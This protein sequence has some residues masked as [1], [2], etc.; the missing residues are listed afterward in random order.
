MNKKN[1][2]LINPP[3]FFSGGIP[4]SL[5]YSVP[6]LGILY[7]A[8]YVNRYSADFKASVIDVAAERLSLE[9]L[10][11]RTDEIAPFAVGIS[12]MTPQLQG[13]VELA[14]CLKKTCMVKPH[15]F[16]GGP[17]ISADPDFLNRF[18]DIFDFAIT[19][20][21]E[22]TFLESLES[23]LNQKSIPRV[24]TGSYIDDLDSVPFPDRRLIDKSKYAKHESL[25]FSRGCP[26]SCYYCS[27]PSVSNKVRYRSVGNMIEE[28]K[29]LFK[30]AQGRI[31]FQD[32]TFTIDKN[33]VLDL[34]RAIKQNQ[35]KIEWRCNTRI[36]LVDEQLLSSMKDAGCSLIHFGIESGNEEL[37]S[38][39][40]K[41]GLF[42][43]KQ[44]FDAF[45]LCKKLKIK[46]A[47]YFI[48]G[49]PMESKADLLQ[50]KDVIL[51]SGIDIMGLSIPTPFP[52]S[53]LYQIAREKGIINEEIIDR[54]ARKELGEGYSGN[55]PVYI[56]EELD[57]EFIF[58]FMKSVNRRFYLSLAL[59]INR[60]K[61][62]IFSLKRLKQ[63]VGDF[64]S[65]VLR[66]MSSRKP[67][68]HKSSVKKY[69]KG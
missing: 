29:Y 34:C 53:R 3:L 4:H 21:A 27:R 16:L 42:T 2:L 13:C 30:R 45:K 11:R 7:L 48:I 36:D 6:P 31:D 64:L 26:Y 20:E 10:V 1:I 39:V 47:G 61:D 51:N 63:D 65:I 28:I 35:L 66:G 69:L 46:I 5:D 55:Y 9:E 54:F 25:I 52:G 68:L 8:T 24:Q 67:Y 17:H 18:A 38:K 59:F 14:H 49:H 33:K 62:D 12:A 40:I 41:K 58:S 43:N 57:K 37:R 23:L 44:M 50:T 15:V 19:G 32:D 56:S 60:I 22:K